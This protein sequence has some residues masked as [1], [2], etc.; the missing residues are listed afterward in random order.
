VT[1]LS[2]SAVL[3]P[4]SLVSN[5]EYSVVL[6]VEFFFSQ[7]KMLDLILLKS[8]EDKGS[9]LTP[10]TARTALRGCRNQYLTQR[11]ASRTTFLTGL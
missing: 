8:R 4:A 2:R 3:V 1:A 7:N 10:I 9:L 6:S 5:A 11:R